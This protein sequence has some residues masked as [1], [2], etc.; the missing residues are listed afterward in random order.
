MRPRDVLL[1]L[2]TERTA[3]VQTIVPPKIKGYYSATIAD[4]KETET[5]LSVSS[6]NYCIFMAISVNFF[7]I[8]LIINRL[9]F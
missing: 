3:C 8:Y 4:R 6:I 2:R 1:S 9:K 5:K 7:P